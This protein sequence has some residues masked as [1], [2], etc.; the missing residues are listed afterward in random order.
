MPKII[1]FDELFWLD[2]IRRFVEEATPKG[3]TVAFRLFRA[4]ND[5]AT[6]HSQT[7]QHHIL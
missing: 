5:G 7:E 3:H 1:R 2:G 6:D 4:E